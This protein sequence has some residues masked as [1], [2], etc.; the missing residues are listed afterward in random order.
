MDFFVMNLF[1]KFTLLVIPV[2]PC[3]MYIYSFSALKIHI[4]KE[5]RDILLSQTPLKTTI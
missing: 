5:T 3:N 4:S 1:K 2:V